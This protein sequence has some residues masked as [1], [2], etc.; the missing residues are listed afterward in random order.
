MIRKERDKLEKK[1]K[2]L[3]E[4]R[5]KLKQR[6]K[7]YSARRKLFEAMLVCYKLIMV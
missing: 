6:L 1:L 2:E 4:D 3:S 7:K 5:D